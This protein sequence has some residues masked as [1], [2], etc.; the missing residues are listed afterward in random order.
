MPFR[1]G[2]DTVQNV[3]DLGHELRVGADLEALNPMWLQAVRLPDPVHGCVADTLQP[4]HRTHTPMGRIRR[5]GVQKVASTMTASLAAVMRFFRPGRGASFSSPSTPAS[6]NRLRHFRIV[7]RLVDSSWAN[8]LLDVPSAARRTIIAR[9]TTF[10]G[11]WGLRTNR[12]RAARSIELRVS[13]VALSQ[14]IGPVCA[15]SA[16]V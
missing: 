4:S 9:N 6:T 2:S 3:A 10:C 12:F 14:M 15:R 16:Q 1:E 5:L 7:G 13:G 11:V 8:W